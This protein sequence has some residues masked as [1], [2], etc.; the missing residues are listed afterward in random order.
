MDL[1]VKEGECILAEE[2]MAAYLAGL[3][4]NL[5]LIHIWVQAAGAQQADIQHR[6][7][8]LSR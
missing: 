4:Q 2:P 8:L 3:I 7:K 5:S 1:Y 6:G